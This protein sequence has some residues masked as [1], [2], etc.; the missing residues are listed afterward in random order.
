[1]MRHVALLRAINVGGTAKLPMA[2]LRE[3]CAQLGWRGVATYIQSGN[4]VFEAE[5]L[6]AQLELAL[7]AGVERRFGFSRP[8]LV[9]NAAQWAAYAA[10]SPFAE[11]ER[12]SPNRLMLC[13]AKSPL[14][15]G[16]EE[17]LQ[18]RAAGGERVQRVG[19]ALWVL[20]PEGPGHSKLTPNLFDRAAGSPV[21]ARN[22][23]TVCK[24]QGMLA[25]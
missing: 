10:G 16:A 6:P 8:V 2:Q 25:S 1:M 3:L 19:E 21:T 9:R 24:L 13:L 5:A 22:W 4:V 7:E 17:A 18:H 14:A 20:Y 23:R 11:A 15:D 12:D